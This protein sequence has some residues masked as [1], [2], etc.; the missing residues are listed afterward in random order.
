M[1][2]ASAWSA[3]YEAATYGPEPASLPVRRRPSA[4]GR[5]RGYGLHCDRLWLARLIASSKTKAAQDVTHDLSGAGER[6]SAC[7][8]T[9][10][11]MFR[12]S[13]FCTT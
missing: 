6:S 12:M 7:D 3:A 1:A 2:S 11:R 4:R 8:Q 5:E 10:N 9:L 13:P